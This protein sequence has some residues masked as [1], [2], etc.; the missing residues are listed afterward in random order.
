MVKSTYLTIVGVI[1]DELLYRMVAIC[2]VTQM[3][4]TCSLD[5]VISCSSTSYVLNKGTH[6]DNS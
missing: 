5:S 1:N 6:V 3:L 4:T 2:F